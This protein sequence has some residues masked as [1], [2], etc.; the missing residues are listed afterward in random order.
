MS[1]DIYDSKRQPVNRTALRVLSAGESY[2]PDKKILTADA[3]Y[4]PA[5]K[6]TELQ[7]EAVTAF[8]TWQ[9]H[10]FGRMTVIGL[11]VDVPNRWVVRCACGTYTL[12][13]LKAI[14][15]PANSADACETCRHLM[16]LQKKQARKRGD[17]YKYID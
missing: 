7:G 15:N 12:R 17:G 2:T 16:Y 14:R 1:R 6:V 4:L 3:D 13:T 8:R 5:R 11:S 9:G 10:R